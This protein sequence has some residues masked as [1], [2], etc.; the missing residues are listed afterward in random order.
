MPHCRTD[1]GGGG[2]R[3]QTLG[4]ESQPALTACGLLNSTVRSRVT[5]AAATSPLFSTNLHT[6]C[7]P[8]PVL[9]L[10]EAEMQKAQL[11]LSR[12]PWTGRNVHSSPRH[13]ASHG[14]EVAESGVSADS[15]NGWRVISEGHWNSSLPEPCCRSASFVGWRA[16]PCRRRRE[17]RLPREPRDPL[18]QQM[19]A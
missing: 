10:A 6:C 1:G 7:V 15:G 16:S 3:K 9:G 5:E 14:S 18:L 13:F 4:L 8:G 19:E 2:G 11:L 17:E 12:R